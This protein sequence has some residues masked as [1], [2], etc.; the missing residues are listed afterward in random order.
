[1]Q[2]GWIDSTT[3]LDSS[4]VKLIMTH[5][6]PDL[7]P[8]QGLVFWNYYRNARSI[9]GTS[10]FFWGGSTEMWFCPEDNTGVIILTNGQGTQ[11]MLNVVDA[12]LTFVAGFADDGCSYLD[13]TSETDPIEVTPGNSFNICGYLS[14]PN[15]EPLTIDMWCRINYMEKPNLLWLEE[16]ILLQPY[17]TQNMYINQDVPVW[18]DPGSYIYTLYT[19]YY[20][21]SLVCDSDELEVLILDSPWKGYSNDWGVEFQW[22]DANNSQETPILTT[23]LNAYPN[24]FNTSTCINYYLPSRSNCKIEIFNLMGQR[25]DVLRNSKHPAG[26]HSLMWDATGYST[27]VYF[28]KLNTATG[29]FIERITLLK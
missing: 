28:I 27:G 24:P 16:N 18:A 23:N 4:S 8:E 17:E 19:G 1:M 2:M 20:M 29:I 6:V 10:G 7:N 15:S 9:W 3:I 26:Q 25:V 12:L 14:N 5:Q 21:D 11:V 22:M 13:V